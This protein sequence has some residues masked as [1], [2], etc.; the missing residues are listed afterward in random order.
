MGVSRRGKGEPLVIFH[1]FM[2]YADYFIY[3]ADML[4]DKFDVVIPDLP[5]FGFT[6]KLAKNTY[7]N[8]AISAKG[9]V[10]N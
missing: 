8:I 5:G 10:K 7:E 3:L 1:G 9:F 4:G 2:C 6:P